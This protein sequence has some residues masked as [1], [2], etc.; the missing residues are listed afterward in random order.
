MRC[1]ELR[2]DTGGGFADDFDGLEDRKLSH[3]VAAE[4]IEVDRGCEVQGFAG[5]EQH[6]EHVGIVT[7][8]DAETAVPTAGCGYRP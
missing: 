2:S 7:Q 3:T 1:C 5:S 8:R 6:I 4:R